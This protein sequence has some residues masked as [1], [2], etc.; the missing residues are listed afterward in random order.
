MKTQKCITTN[1]VN[2]YEQ[3]ISVRKCSEPNQ[4][5]KQSQKSLSMLAY[6]HL[7]KDSQNN[8]VEYFS[9]A[10]KNVFMIAI[11]KYMGMQMHGM[12]SNDAK[13]AQQ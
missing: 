7:I 10:D 11:M 3:T 1:Q 5:V 6:N 9:S 4:K 8:P 13:L 12:A 2:I